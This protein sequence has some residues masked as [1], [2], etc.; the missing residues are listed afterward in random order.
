MG[1]E[2]FSILRMG[3]TCLIITK[4][5]GHKRQ[6]GHDWTTFKKKSLILHGK[7]PICKDKIQVSDLEGRVKSLLFAL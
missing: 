7:N 1:E 6:D 2:L 5:R 3:K 4:S